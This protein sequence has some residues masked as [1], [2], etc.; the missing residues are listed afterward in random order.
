MADSIAQQVAEALAQMQVPGTSGS[1]NVK[2]WTGTPQSYGSYG[3]GVSV[4][5]PST[6]RTTSTASDIIAQVQAMAANGDPN[7]QKFTQNL[8]NMGVLYSDREARYVKSVL[9]GTQDA[10]DMYLSSDQKMSFSDWIDSRAKQG[11]A[12]GMGG[13]GS[14]GGYSGPTT[15]VS[16]SIT[17]A[18]TADALLNTAARDMI[19]RDLNADELAKYTKQFNAAEQA[20][21]QVTTTV[22]GVGSSSSTTRTAPDKGEVL[23]KILAT[24]KDFA[25]NQ[26][27]TNVMD[28][29]LGR[30]KEGQAVING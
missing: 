5:A 27:D 24:N 2:I 22:P 9:A 15:T 4:K 14:G 17:D 6:S 25:E 21:P 23:R 12:N 16:R 11:A 18:V 3:M 28:M 10:I 7:Y 26:I 29:F 1:E 30:I 20:N 19:G 8:L 13:G